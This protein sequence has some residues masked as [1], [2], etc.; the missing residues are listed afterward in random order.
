MD[1]SV[2]HQHPLACVK[3]LADALEKMS[4]KFILD[5]IETVCRLLIMLKA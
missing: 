4:P 2:L 3:L 1:G 5:F